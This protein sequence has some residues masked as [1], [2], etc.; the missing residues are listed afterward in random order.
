MLEYKAGWYGREVIA[1]DRWYPSSKT[2]SSCGAL[3]ASLPL[4]IRE[5]ACRCGTVHDRDVNAAKNILAAGLAVSACGDGVR[6]SRSW[7][8]EAS[9]SEAGKPFRE[10][11]NARPSDRG[12]GQ[13]GP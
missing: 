8:G 1:V 5:W 12:G 9:V 2:C 11:E 7:S 6:P 13:W 3:V 4:N 10:E